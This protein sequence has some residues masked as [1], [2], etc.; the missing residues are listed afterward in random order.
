MDYDTVVVGAGPAGTT[1]AYHLA[2]AGLKT[3]LVEKEKM[4]RYKAC[5]G[6]LTRKVQKALGLELAP[7]SEDRIQTASVA[8]G[9]HRMCMA[10]DRP[11]AW[12]VMRDQFDLLLARRA[13]Q[14]GAEV[15]EQTPVTGI[16]YDE[17]G[18]TVS[19]RSDTIRARV[20][21]G[22]DG[23]NGIVRRS[24]DFSPYHWLAAAI[25]AELQ[26][27]PADIEKWHG[28]L[29]MDLGAIQW[30]YGWI[31]PKAEHLSVGVGTLMRPHRPVNLRA[32]LTRYMQ[33][34][35]SLG[36]A[37]EIFT[38]GHRLPLGGYPGRYHA[39]NAVLVG[40]AAGLV[41]PLTAEGI[42]YSIRSGQIA[43]EVIEQAFRS[44]SFDLAPH[45]T[46]INREI[47]SDFRFALLLMQFLYRAPRL[48]YYI[49]K[50]SKRTQSTLSETINGEIGYRQSVL[51]WL[52]GPQQA[53]S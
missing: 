49:F 21:V 19:T 37:R 39:S 11:V 50:W 30:G 47:N 42:Y 51:S 34:E 45:T 43:A 20:V 41:D 33:S 6:G 27:P 16:T 5:G 24:A 26:A 48:A 9:S 14:A 23:V 36:N 44:E 10:F 2:R 53:G 7:I 35:P 15:R 1:A 46:Q 12:C 28:V 29:H 18:A 40:D 38:R 22:A 8:C 25:E 31:F 4:P 13:S 17:K 52:R 32:E 3:L